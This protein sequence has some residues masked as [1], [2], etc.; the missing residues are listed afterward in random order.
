MQLETILS[1]KMLQLIDGYRVIPDSIGMSPARVFRLEPILQGPMGSGTRLPI[2]VKVS[3]KIFNGTTYDVLRE[4]QVLEWLDGKVECPKVLHA[5]AHGDY[6]VLV[7]SEVEGQLLMDLVGAKF[8]GFNSKEVIQCYVQ[9]LKTLHSIPIETCPILSD[10][11]FRLNELDFLLENELA[12]IEDFRAGNTPFETPQMLV[13]FLK[14]DPVYHARTSVGRDQQ[15]WVFSHGDL[16]D[17]NLFIKDKCFYGLIDW[18]RGGIADPWLD[19]AFCVRSIRED[20]AG[21]EGDAN[22]LINY[23]FELLAVVPDWKAIDYY[24]YLDELF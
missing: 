12:A 1:E 2:F 8:E 20:L 19:I 14:S 10:L 11:T 24:L 16:C 7:M 22:P 15:R 3:H 5:E 23:F 4:K 13:N 9:C 17:S 21:N 18:G 6:H